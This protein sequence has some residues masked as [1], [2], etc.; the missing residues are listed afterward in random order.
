[1]D[2]RM[3]A[4]EHYE[5]GLVLKQVHMFYQAIEDFRT[6]VLD[7]HFAAK[8]H[9]Q[10]ALCLRATDH[11]EEAV[12]AFR[13]ALATATLSSEEQRH[14]LYHMG[15]TFESLS[16]YAESLEVY[17]WIRKEDPGFR[18]LA[19]RIKHLS[20]GGKGPVP[21]SPWQG[22][23]TEVFTCGRQLKPHMVSFLEQTGQWLGRHAETIKTPAVAKGTSSH[24]SRAHASAVV[25]PKRHSQP[26]QRDRTVESRRHARV[27]VHLRSH[28]SSKGRKVTGEGD[29]CD[30]SPWGCRVTSSVAMPVG[31]DLEFCIF[32]RDAAHPFIIEGATVRWINSAEFGLSFTNV[33]PGV[34][35]QIA[36]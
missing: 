3:S 29:L 8:A 24:A 15:Q 18:D 14:I 30:L 27:P 10:I 26:A 36:Q 2:K 6:A 32:P 13:Q 31:T 25:L 1:M 17:G 28:F 12:M 7:P 5:R 33:R 35:K 4:F 19:Q 23:M 22:W 9:V 11:H 21:Q 20:S 16:R 34:Q